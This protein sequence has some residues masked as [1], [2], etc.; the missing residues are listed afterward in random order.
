MENLTDKQLKNRWTDIKKLI[1]VRQLLAYRVGIPLEKW[2]EYMLKVPD[3]DEINRIYFAIQED[4]RIKTLRIR[5]PLSKIVGY[6]E[7]KVFSKK[8]GVSDTSIREIIEGKKL[9]AGYEIIDKLE[10]FL[11]VVLPDFEMSIENTLTLKGYSQDYIGEIATEIS[12]IADGLKFYCLKL[13]EM[14]KKRESETDWKGNTVL[15][16]KSIEFAISRLTSV[17]NEVDLFW[18]VYIDLNKTSQ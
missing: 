7:S 1:K 9:M 3:A 2:D 4:R 8:S 16:S 11:S 15:P 12:Q 5:E 18:D 14:A 17:K 10:L 13:I 6:R